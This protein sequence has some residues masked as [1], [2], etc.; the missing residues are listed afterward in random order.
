LSIKSLISDTLWYGL[1]NILGRFINFFLMIGLGLY[2]SP[3]QISG[4]NMV[5][6]MVPFLN[7][8][9][10]MGLETTYLRYEK[11]EGRQRLFNILQNYVL[12][13]T[14]FFTSILWLGANYWMQ[15][16]ELGNKPL[17]YNWMLVVLFFD[18]LSFLI[19][20]KLR[21]EGKAK[22]YAFIK[23]INILTF[24]I[25][26]LFWLVLCAKKL[27]TNSVPNFIYN[28]NI[29]LGYFIIANGIAS[30]VT[31]IILVQKM[32]Q[33]RFQLGNSKI[34]DDRLALL[35]KIFSYSLPIVVV[36]FG[37]MIN[38]FLSRLVYMKVL[39]DSQEV[40]E[41]EFGI[42][43][44]CYRISMLATIFIQVFRMAAEP[45]FFKHSGGRDEPALFARVTKLFT[46]ICCF[47]FLG[48]VFNLPI[49]YS[50]L[51]LRFKEYGDGIMIIPV[52]TMAN[53]FLGIY[54]NFSIWYK[55]HKDTMKGALIT[56]AGVGITILLNIILIPLYKYHGASWA[57]LGCYLAM[58]TISYVWGQKI[59]PKPYNIKKMGIYLATVAALFSIY[60]FIIGIPSIGIGI[61]SMLI[62]MGIFSGLVWYLDKEEIKSLIKR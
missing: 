28:Q 51:T 1:S 23:L 50:F 5:Y 48:I 40:L 55:Q 13:I 59:N 44:Q 18:N 53:I 38:D 8:L 19:F 62:A 41:T 14:I 32:G 60:H 30:I 43:A 21:V 27:S 25:L 47:I 24:S 22:S 9:F 10:T 35:K 12:I 49:I 46:I 37:G 33:F 15:T 45:F 17:Y 42:F 58:V 31:F 29:N 20:A 4:V 54:Y 61:L 7:I 3:A 39:P 6:V 56:F 16:F 26:C 36:G 2:Y 34:A 57:T 52:L 11:E